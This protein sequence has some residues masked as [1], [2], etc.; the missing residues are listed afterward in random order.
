MQTVQN[1]RRLEKL[2]YRRNMYPVISLIFTIMR[3]CAHTNSQTGHSFVKIN[4]RD[5]ACVSLH[6]T[7]ARLR[8]IRFTCFK[9]CNAVTSGIRF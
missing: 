5:G 7:L 2:L 9:T 1:F 6:E 8:E 4:K 3:L